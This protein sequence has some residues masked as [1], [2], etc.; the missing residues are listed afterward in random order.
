M[1]RYSKRVSLEELYRNLVVVIVDIISCT[2]SRHV[3]KHLY[4]W[5][6]FW[7]FLE[8][9]AKMY[10]MHICSICRASRKSL[11]M[12][13]LS[14]ELWEPTAWRLMHN[15]DQPWPCM[16]WQPSHSFC[17]RRPYLKRLFTRR[18]TFSSLKYFFFLW[19]LII[20]CE[21]GAWYYRSY[22]NFFQWLL[23]DHPPQETK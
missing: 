11:H 3:C 10:L 19:K 9:T 14:S 20:F 7:R 21:A 13:D 22:S 5:C 12:F 4:P 1:T 15:L 17:L 8:I 2:H 18:Q 6:T 23:L 16:L